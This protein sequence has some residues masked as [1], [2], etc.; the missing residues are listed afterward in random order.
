M[1]IIVIRGGG[2][3][4]TGIGHRLYRAGFKI[5]ILDVEEP[6]AIRRRVS[7]CEAI[8]SGEIVVEGVRA[9]YCKNIN[10]SMKALEEG[11]LPVLVDELGQNINQIK[12]IAV[13]DSILAKRNLGTNKCMAPITIG[14]GP[15]FEAG[16]DVDLIIE[17]MRG[18]NLG[19]VIYEGTAAD[20]TGIPG[21]I[22][23][24]TQERIIRAVEDGCI[25]WSCQ[26]GD[27][28]RQGQIIGN[29]SGFD[30]KAKIS[31]V[32]RGLIKDGIYVNRGLKIGDIDP[33]GELIN[34]TTISDKA[35]AIGGGVLEAIMYL[36]K[37][38]E[39]HY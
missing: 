36:W 31:G 26:I 17:S 3:I 11:D 15:G 37:V 25:I 18:H 34:S 6:L 28:V 33:R 24:F 32:I 13:I 27:M 10:D 8:Y 14:V 35:R 22:L 23:E 5:I 30:I 9:V 1:D 29:I 38:K 7:F 4:A 16:I 39:I 19:R 12:P 21:S 20:N 2:D